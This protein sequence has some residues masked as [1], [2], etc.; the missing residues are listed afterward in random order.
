MSEAKKSVE[1]TPDRVLEFL[2]SMRGRYIMSQAL[3]LAMKEINARPYERQEP[4]NVADMQY[5]YDHLFGLYSEL[6]DPEEYR[7]A[8]NSLQ[9][10]LDLPE[11]SD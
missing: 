7:K 9:D 10:T 5:L 3:Y 11:T 8:I 1:D 4:S 2:N 6:T